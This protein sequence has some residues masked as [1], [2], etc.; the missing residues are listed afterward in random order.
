MLQPPK[1][2]LNFWKLEV[3]F[4]GESLSNYTNNFSN[5]GDLVFS[6]DPINICSQEK[7]DENKI[8]FRLFEPLSCATLQTTVNLNKKITY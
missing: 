8:Y 4:Y 2:H 1:E 7:R 6:S 3:S 5:Y